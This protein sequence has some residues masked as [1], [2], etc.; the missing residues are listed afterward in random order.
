MLTPNQ[1]E[2]NLG[3]F[4]PF[5]SAWGKADTPT[6]STFYNDTQA[7]RY[8]RESAYDLYVQAQQLLGLPLPPLGV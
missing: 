2:A 1:R 5:M 7:Y 6:R 4:G 8:G 3:Y